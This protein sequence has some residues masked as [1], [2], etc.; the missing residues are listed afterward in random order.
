MEQ[1][2]VVKSLNK[3]N[4]AR[5]PRYNKCHDHFVAHIN[6][7]GYI[8]GIDEKEQR[9]LEKALGY[10]IGTLAPHSQFWKEYAIPMTDRDLRLDLTNPK[11]QLDYYLIK[12]DPRVANSVNELANWPKAEYVVHDEE[13]NAR[14]ENLEIDNEARAIHDYMEL[15][16]NEKRNYLKL[17]GKHSGSMS[18]ARVVNI[19]FKIAK[20]DPTEFNRISDLPGAK[21]MILIY[22][23]IEKGILTVRGGIYYYN[24][25]SLGH[26]ETDTAAFLD[27]NKNQDLK[28]TLKGKLDK[29]N[30]EEKEEA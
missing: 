5:M 26:G 24:D 2:I 15:S 10:D 18:D 8:T 14:K 25:M 4:W 30:K 1:S 23:L 21:T 7:T 11:D 9:R 16:S 13:E 20:E 28:I 22:D 19:L 12:A 6:R 29:L 27:S 3:P 17:M